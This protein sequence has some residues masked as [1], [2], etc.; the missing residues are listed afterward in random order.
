MSSLLIPI[1]L[2]TDTYI[3]CFQI[4]IHIPK[5]ASLATLAFSDIIY[6]FHIY[7]NLIRTPVC[8]FKFIPNC[9][10][11]DLCFIKMIPTPD[12]VIGFIG[13]IGFTTWE[14]AVPWAPWMLFTRN[15]HCRNLGSVMQVFV[16]SL[17]L[18]AMKELMQ[19]HF[20]LLVRS[21]E[22]TPLFFYSTELYKEGLKLSGSSGVVR[23]SWLSSMVSK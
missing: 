16:S 12:I 4:P 6:Q 5:S 15:N 13:Y 22:V 17:T 9:C 20:H 19:F 10:S 11:T 2:N 14:F 23:G 3:V 18:K 8:L 7:I 1:K 21:L